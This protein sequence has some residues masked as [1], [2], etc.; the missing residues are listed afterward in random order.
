MYGTWWEGKEDPVAANKNVYSWTELGDKFGKVGDLDTKSIRGHRDICPSIWWI[1]RLHIHGRNWVIKS[2]RIGIWIR[3]TTRGLHGIGTIRCIL[4]LHIHRRNW[5]EYEGPLEDSMVSVPFLSWATGTGIL[6]VV[7]RPR[8][9]VPSWFANLWTW[10]FMT[11]TRTDLIKL[12]RNNWNTFLPR[13]VVRNENK[14]KAVHATV[15]HTVRHHESPSY[16]TVT[17]TRIVGDRDIGFQLVL[18]IL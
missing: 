13:N 2:K 6:P 7:E 17:H 5:F 9:I 14:L 8:G 15:E 10:L 18:H 11:I 3:R 4:R 12:L 16:T 1:L